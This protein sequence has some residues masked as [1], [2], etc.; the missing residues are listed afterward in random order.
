MAASHQLE[1]QQHPRL[2]QIEWK[3]Q[4]VGW[5]VWAL[6]LLAGLAGLFGG[7]GYL[8]HK[9]STS[10][11]GSTEVQYERFA[12]YHHPT[13]LE[14]TLQPDSERQ[15][16]YL[17]KVSQSFLDK[18]EIRRAEPEPQRHIISSDGVTYSF[19]AEPGTAQVRVLLHVDYQKTGRVAGEIGLAGHQPAQIYQFVYP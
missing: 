5:A 7:S 15:E 9:V 12:Q 8:S 18:V 19:L 17:V 3:I 14:L 16:E 6:I 13:T 11:D 1:L 2:Q 10:S 4:R